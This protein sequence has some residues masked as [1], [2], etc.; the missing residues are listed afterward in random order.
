M[1]K[2]RSPP[3]IRLRRA[4]G[5]RTRKIRSGAGLLVDMGPWRA[6]HGCEAIGS[7]RR[8]ELRKHG[9]RGWTFG[10]AD[11]KRRLGVCKYRR[12]RIEIA[13][14]LRPAQ[15][16]T[17]SVLDTLRHEIAHAIAGPAAGTARPGR[18]SPSG[19]GPRPVPATT[20]H[21]T[22]VKP[23]DWQATCP[24]C[25]K[26][27][28]LY[29]RPRSLSGYRC[30]CE[31]RSPLTFEYVGD[32]ARRP[33]VPVTARGVGELGGEVCGLRDRASAGH[34]GRRRASGGAVGHTVADILATRPA[35][36]ASRLRTA[37]RHR[38]DRH[39][40]RS[41]RAGLSVALPASPG[42]RIGES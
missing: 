2:A 24:A 11:T 34:A 31:A 7:D 30:R 38:L 36:T 12:K 15:P 40:G 27:V 9:L 18:R 1:V 17:E 4:S 21:E 26:T 32:P 20:S 22:V 8:P 19:W 28:H 35:M 14:Y 3:P 41:R 39:E 13:E 37:P 23:G 5:L 6:G 16:P 10:L 25:E 33:A 42:I 29:R